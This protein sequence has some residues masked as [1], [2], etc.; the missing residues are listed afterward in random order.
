MA[1][2]SIFK[3]LVEGQYVAEDGTMTGDRF[4]EMLR[5]HLLTTP[6]NYPSDMVSKR[7]LASIRYAVPDR[8]QVDHKLS[9]V[10]VRAV[11]RFGTCTIS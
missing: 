10:S 3:T 7:D 1:W 4:K 8:Q 11:N 9:K 5:Y 6:T 2:S